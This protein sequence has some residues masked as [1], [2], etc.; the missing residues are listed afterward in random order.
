MADISRY[1]YHQG[2]S[3][4][5]HDLCVHMADVMCEDEIGVWTMYELAFVI[6][7][8]STVFECPQWILV[9]GDKIALTP[10]GMKSVA[11]E[12]S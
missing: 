6:Y 3:A 7:K 4:L 5:A 8:M 9:A 1:L 10:F 12:E 11:Q 2:G